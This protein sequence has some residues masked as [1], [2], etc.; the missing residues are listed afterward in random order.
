M[1]ELLVRNL[2]AR[3][4]LNASEISTLNRIVGRERTVAIGQDIV[5]EGSRPTESTVL[6]DGIAA[7]Y[8]VLEDGKRQ[9]TALQVP[10]DFVDLHAFML[11]KMDHGVIALST[12][13]VATA[14]HKDLTTVTETSPHLTRMLWLSTVID[15]AI[16]REWIVAMGRRSKKSHLAHLICELFTRLSLVG[17]VTNNGFYLPLSQAEVADALGVSL[18][19]FNKTLQLL[20]RDGVVRWADRHI[21]V[22]QW[23]RLVEIGEFDDAYLNLNKEAR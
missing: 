20:R 14:R 10:G 9:I 19:H 4:D 7:R 6:L 22:V 15:G 21:T 13:R 5:A 23:D 3:D 18:V 11:K 2:G 12:C 17:L 8:R 16:H 1:I